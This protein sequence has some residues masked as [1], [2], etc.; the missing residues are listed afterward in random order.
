[1]SSNAKTIDELWPIA[2]SLMVLGAIGTLLLLVISRV[3]GTAVGQL[4]SGGTP[5]GCHGDEKEKEATT[6]REGE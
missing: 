3:V 2:F 4:E 6:P 1:M 5:C